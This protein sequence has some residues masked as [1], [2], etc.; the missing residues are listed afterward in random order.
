[1]KKLFLMMAVVMT[2]LLVACS[3]NKKANEENR[4]SYRG[5]IHDDCRH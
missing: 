1:M 4:Y 2:A 3:G 5:C